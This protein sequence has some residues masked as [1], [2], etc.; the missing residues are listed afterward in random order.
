MNDVSRQYDAKDQVLKA[1]PKPC[2]EARML[3]LTILD[4]N[5]KDFLYEEG[6]TALEYLYGKEAANA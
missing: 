3:F 2:D 6:Q 1:Y 5:D 4:S